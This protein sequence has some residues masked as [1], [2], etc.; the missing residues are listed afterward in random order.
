[1]KC[2]CGHER[3][4]HSDTDKLQF[5][6]HQ[7]IAKRDLYQCG[8]PGFRERVNSPVHPRTKAHEYCN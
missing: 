5:N 6:A 8:C 4:Y 7:C 1:M 2:M 3:A